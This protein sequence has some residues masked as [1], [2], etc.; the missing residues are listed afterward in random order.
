MAPLHFWAPIVTTFFGVLGSSGSQ[1]PLHNDEPVAGSQNPGQQTN[2]PGVGMQCSQPLT[3][4]FSQCL[5]GFSNGACN[6][7]C[8]PG[9]GNQPGQQGYW[10]P[11][12]PGHWHPGQQGY[13]EP[14]Q[15]GHWHPGQ[16][17]HW[18]PGQ[19]DQGHPGQ[20]DQGQSGQRP[21]NGLCNPPCHCNCPD[22][23]QNEAGPQPGVNNDPNCR[24]LKIQYA[25]GT[26]K[27]GRD[28]LDHPNQAYD[29][30]KKINNTQ[31]WYPMDTWIAAEEGTDLDIYIRSQKVPDSRG[32]NY[33]IPAGKH[34]RRNRK[35]AAILN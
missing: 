34:T 10:H 29:G 1:I 7:V 35:L 32:N 14:G 26:V 24:W 9:S 8:N 19:Q 13:W 2:S 4:C 31:Y 11:G 30:T 3:S 33:F 28:I 17:G 21:V 15:P 12:Q 27:G 18:R 25:D 5:H 6:I 23:N 22:G 16:P 20:S